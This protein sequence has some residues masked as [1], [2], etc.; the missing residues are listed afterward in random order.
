ML[1]PAV[2]AEPD[3][4]AAL[5]AIRARASAGDPLAQWCLGSLLYYGSAGTAQAA[6][7]IRRAADQ[8]VAD[9]ALQLGRMHEAGFGVPYDDASALRWYA[10]AAR[11]GVA[12]AQRALAEYYTRGRGVAAN[13]ATAIEWLHRA[14]DGDDLQ[15]QYQLGQ[16]YFDG[17]GVP[18]DYVAAYVWF[19]IAA[20]QTPL[21]DN[22]KQLMELRNIAA[23][24]MTPAQL[25]EAKRRTRAW[26]PP[27]VRR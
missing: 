26:Q 11:A 18:R 15:A 19:S 3:A 14:A 16:A 6:D 25:I 20:G 23:V 2:R 4:D 21:V 12:A 5:A 27:P 7:W 24:R 17:D 9:A 10:E 1:A 13:R 22:R 8:R